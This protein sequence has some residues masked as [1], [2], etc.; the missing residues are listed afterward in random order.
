MTLNPIRPADFWYV[1]PNNEVQL[2]LIKK[3]NM[4]QKS[5]QQISNE[6]NGQPPDSGAVEASYALGEYMLFMEGMLV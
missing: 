2:D 3:K 5:L 6:N 1:M 4:Q